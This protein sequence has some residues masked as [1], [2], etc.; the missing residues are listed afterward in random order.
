[1]HRQQLHGLGGGVARHGQLLA[2]QRAQPLVGRQKAPALHAQ[3][4]GQQRAQ[5]RQHVG[6][7]GRGGSGG[8]AR[9]HVAVGVDGL[10]RVVRG[11]VQKPLAV[12]HQIGVQCLSVV[13]KQLCC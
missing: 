5:L 9:Q 8:K 10:Q 7:L 2:A 11:Q 12:L 13:R 4:G 3:G 6:A 1:M